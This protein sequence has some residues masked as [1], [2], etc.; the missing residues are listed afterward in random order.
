[1]AYKART[2]AE[3]VANTIMDQLGGSG[4]LKMMVG[5][6]NAVAEMVE[7]GALT[8]RFKGSRKANG[9]QVVLTQMD[10]YRMT[11]FSIGRKDPSQIKVVETLEDIYCDQLVEMFE[12]QTGLYL[13]F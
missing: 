7:R 2:Q 11:F 3:H 12:N 1:M 9:L 13:T 8:F 10:T 6:Y 5:A 4:R